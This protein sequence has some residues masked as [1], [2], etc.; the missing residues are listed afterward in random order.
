MANT[1]WSSAPYFADTTAFR[2]WGA[3]IN[4]ALAATGL[5]QTSDT[6]Q[7]NWAT[8]SASGSTSTDVGYEVWRFNDALQST[9]PI[10]F[11]LVYGTGSGSQRARI[12]MSAVGTATNG[13]GTLSVPNAASASFSLN[14]LVGGGSVDST[15]RT[16]Y[17]AGDGSGVAV[18]FFPESSA[19]SQRGGFVI[20]RFRDS[21]GAA[22]ADGFVVLTIGSSTGTSHQMFANGRFFTGSYLPA[23]IPQATI[24]TTSD[25]TNTYVAPFMVATPEEQHVKMAAAFATADAATVGNQTVSHLGAARTYKGMGSYLTN[26]DIQNRSGVGILMWWSD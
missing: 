8:V 12:V 7:I 1:S 3:A 19:A 15:A 13:A 22:T 18:A 9:A 4:T 5:V 26:C 14:T 16:S 2:A 11:K 21:S 23:M 24:T 17:A 25:G 10:F 20:D 6:G